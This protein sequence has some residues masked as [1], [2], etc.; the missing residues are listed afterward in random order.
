VQT[1]LRVIE[2]HGECLQKRLAAVEK[3]AADQDEQQ[4]SG[5]GG[6]CVGLL[7]VGR[8]DGWA[9]GLYI[10]ADYGVLPTPGAADAKIAAPVCHPC[11]SRGYGSLLVADTAVSWLFLGFLPWRPP[12]R[13]SDIGCLTSVV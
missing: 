13:L 11:W 8:R 4:A 10:G 9:G 5:A 2:A 7:R 3:R 12:H 6:A 1:E